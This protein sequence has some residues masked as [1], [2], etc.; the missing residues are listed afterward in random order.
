MYELPGIVVSQGI[1]IGI[2]HKKE[3]KKVL[4]NLT[5][6][7]PDY[8]DMEIERFDHTVHN[9][10]SEIDELIDKYSN[11][12]EDFDILNTHK[13]LIEDPELKNEVISRVSSD[14]VSLE[15][16]IYQ[17]TNEIIEFFQNMSNDYYAQRANDYKDISQRLLNSLGNVKDDF[18]VDLRDSDILLIPD[19]PPSDVSVI[20]DKKVQGLILQKGNQTS[21]SAIIARSLNLPTI[22]SVDF[23][24]ILENQVLIIDGFNGKV[25][26]DPDESTILHYQALM[27]DE[28]LQLKLLQEYKKCKA[29]TKDNQVINLFCNIEFPH[30]VHWVSDYN[31]DGIGLF[32]TEFLY[33]DRE[34]FPDEEEQFSIYKEMI[35]KANPLPVTIRTIDVGG[36]KLTKAIRIG[37]EANPYLGC[38]GIR[39]SLRYVEIFKTQLKAIL[40][41]SVFGSARIMI[42]MIS[43]IDEIIQVKALIEECKDELNKALQPYAYT[44]LGIMIEVPSA[45]LEAEAFAEIVDFFSIG[46]N[47][48]IQYALAVDRGNDII[49]H[50]YNPY[51]PAVFK[52]LWM[53]TDAAKRA[54]I[55]ISICGE[56]AAQQEFIPIFL[57][58]G[59]TDLSMSPK[60]L[61]KIKRLV[62]ELS[63]SDLSDLKDEVLKCKDSKAVKNLINKFNPIIGE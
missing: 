62:T 51:H 5:K 17:Y 11:S 29:I 2:A 4:V 13:V 46:T 26:V 63:C 22:G 44:P 53:V 24:Q 8:V 20:V 41:A 47:D 28:I 10:I 14:L 43:S 54:N 59:I 9:V 45:V 31:S 6:I 60:H 42:P 37:K 27:S 33:M 36:D 58:M 7:E 35:E 18:Y 50:Y 25:I 52:L 3:E 34:T 39:F 16:A 21:H 61:L 49:P 56:M 32:R 38:R 12:K 30:E 55:P 48:L 40:R 57:S 23:D 19:I 1:A 15:Y